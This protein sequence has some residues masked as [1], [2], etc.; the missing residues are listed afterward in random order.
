M[1]ISDVT[2]LTKLSKKS[3]YYYINE[4]LLTPLSEPGNGYLN[5]TQEDVQR[6]QIIQRLRI[7]DVPVSDIRVMLDRPDS[8][9]FYLIRHHKAL[10]QKA[11]MLQWQ[12]QVMQELAD[13]LEKEASLEE[14]WRKTQT[15]SPPPSTE[16]ALIDIIDAEMLANYF[17]GTFMRGEKLNEY[18]RF[19]WDRL[20]KYIVANQNADLVALRDFLYSLSPVATSSTFMMHSQSIEEIAALTPDQYDLYIQTM[21]DA[22]RTNIENPTWVTAWKRCYPCFIR[23][24]AGFYDGAANEIIREFTPLFAQYQTNVNYCCS[25]M[26]AYLESPQGG[27]LYARIQAQLGDSLDI[28]ASSSGELAG[29]VSFHL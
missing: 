24:Q 20:V 21:I 12:N 2:R 27:A 22:T 17:W 11:S 6:L 3:I 10:S 25:R 16:T 15:I 13:H 29:L 28:Y 8:S 14:L 9:V 5:F 18:R 7:L 23:P 1:R 4:G 19:L 26:R